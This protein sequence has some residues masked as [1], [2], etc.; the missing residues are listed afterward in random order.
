MKKYLIFLISVNLLLGCTKSEDDVPDY[1]DARE[2]S[3][4]I[5]NDHHGQIDN[6]PRIKYIVD[7]ERQLKNVI[8]VSA[9]DIFSGN[10][11]VDYYP[12]KGYPMIDMMNRVGFD[13]SVIGNHEYDYGQDVL[14]ERMEQAQFK[15][16]CANVDMNNTG[17]PEPYEYYTI[18]KNDFRITFLG[19]VETNGKNDAT[20]PSTHPFR[21]E[22]ISF[23]P[24]EDVAGQYA[25]TKNSEDADLFVALTHIGHD[26]YG[27]Y[28]GDYQ[29]AEM[30][31]YF[32]MIIGGH[33]HAEVDT[34]V[35]GIY[36]YQAGSYLQKL[37]KIELLVHE[38]KIVH[39]EFYLIN[40]DIYSN[41]DPGLEST[42]DQYNESMASVLNEVIGYS[43]QNHQKSQVGC[44]YTDALRERMEVDIT[45]QNTGGIRAG[46]DQGEITVG[47]IYAF[48]PFNNNAMK[49][50][51]S[52]SA[53]KTFLKGSSSGFYYS[54]VTINQEGNNIIIRNMD[55][56][57]IP[58]NV[59]LKLG[60]NDYIP[61]VYDTWFPQDGETQDYTTA[62]AIIYYL[63][64]INDE[65]NVPSC[66]R[67]FKFQN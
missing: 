63:K 58:D 60:I 43:H 11:V 2:L 62:E 34:K 18:E 55:N 6:F 7:Q 37:G 52:I 17:L 30:Y 32:D 20:I 33:S 41:A 66:E 65:V 29:L 38:K 47:E 40:L 56:E 42:V 3:I 9:G 5:I 16:V 22:G 44:F 59:I 25:N 10:P 45:F 49:Y 61:A 54:G 67:Y 46:L 14:K 64:M 53:I 13:I 21:V 28:M 15:W 12:E 50:E 8:V 48:D 4:F 51:M 27:G 39:Q 57:I 31:P 36:I 26:G 24:P 23:E 1:S 19:L 35:N